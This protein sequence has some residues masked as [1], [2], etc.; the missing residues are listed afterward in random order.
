MSQLVPQYDLSKISDA[1]QFMRFC[2][3]VVHQII[4]NQNGN[5]DF[6]NFLSQTVTVTFSAASTNTAIAQN[7]GKTGV[8]YIVVSQSAAGSIYRGTGDT[9]KTLFLQCSAPLTA[10]LVLF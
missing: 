10:T 4:Q 2:S 1:D 7:L 3:T 6:S 5:L 8:N 9:L